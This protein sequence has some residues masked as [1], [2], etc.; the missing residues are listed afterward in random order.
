MGEV[1]VMRRMGILL[2]LFCA[3]VVAAPANEAQMLARIHVEAIGG[4]FVWDC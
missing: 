2:L 4:D 1:D 3:G